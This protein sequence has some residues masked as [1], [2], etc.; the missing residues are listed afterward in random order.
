MNGPVTVAPPLAAPPPCVPATT[1]TTTT[2]TTTSTVPGTTTTTTSISPPTTT[3]PPQCLSDA[4]CG[5][6]NICNGIET[7]RAG[8]CTAGTPLNCDDGDPCTL[9]SCAPASGCQH[10][11][12]ADLASCSIVIPGGE[13]RKADCYVFADVAGSHPIDNPKTLSCADGDPTCDMDGACNNVCDLKVRLC[14]NSATM[15]PCT[16][17]SQLTSLKFKSHPATFTLNTPAQLTGAQCGAV[18]DVLLPVKVSKKGKKSTGVL[19]VTASAKAP[20]GTKPPTDKDTYVMKCVP[21][22]AR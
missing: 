7:C 3:L 11:M 6:G 15:S 18:H 1:T 5:D 19:K 4:S 14:I 13:N 8:V 16:P 21:G 22:C 17:P 12:V 20:K 10:T 2:T 9:D